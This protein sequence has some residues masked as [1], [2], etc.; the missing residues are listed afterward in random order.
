MDENILLSQQHHSRRPL[1]SLRDEASELA[2]RFSLPG[3]PLGK[4]SEM[5]APDL[6]R[7]AC[8][9]AFLGEPQLLI[10]ERPTTGV[11]PEIMNA[12]MTS[13]QV[14]RAR[15]AAVLWT[16]D[17]AQEWHDPGIK[18]T[19]RCTMTGSQMSILTEG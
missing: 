17:N 15:G 4:P 8:V 9:R 11:Y 13:V 2:R 18:A 19:L 1:A 3:L 14:A 5:R 6:R 7:A 16:T 12:L 10:L